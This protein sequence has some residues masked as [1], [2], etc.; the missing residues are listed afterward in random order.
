MITLV[1]GTI[2]SILVLGGAFYHSSIDLRVFL[3][4]EGILIVL[5]GTF[6]IFLMST[7]KSRLVM[8]FKHMVRYLS[9]AKS[10]RRLVRSINECSESISQGVVPEGKSYHPFLRKSLEWLRAGL[11]GDELEL[12]L[13]EGAQMEI[14]RIHGSAKILTNIAKYPPALGMVGTVFGIIGIFNTLG[15]DE[16]QSMLGANLAF[17]MT[18]TLYGLVCSNFIFAPIAELLTQAAEKEEAELSLII[19]T[20]KHWSKKESTFFIKEHMELYDDVA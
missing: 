1:F 14:E 10:H 4:I 12:L 20:V 16:G 9:G 6:S 19:E 18:A 11:K 17:A 5:G 2:F 7:R 15:T 13:N 3:N 8:L